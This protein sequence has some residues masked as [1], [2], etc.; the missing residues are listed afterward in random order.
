MLEAKLASICLI[1]ETLFTFFL[2]VS[3]QP[4]KEV[5][6]T[7]IFLCSPDT[8]SYKITLYASKKQAVQF[9]RTD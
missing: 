4:I 3:T 6:Y 8:Y 5:C 7:Y 1:L 9:A 2:C